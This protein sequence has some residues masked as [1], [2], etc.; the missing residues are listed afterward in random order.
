[1]NVAICA[2]QIADAPR[3]AEAFTGVVDEGTCHAADV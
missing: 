3:V 2:D 1:M